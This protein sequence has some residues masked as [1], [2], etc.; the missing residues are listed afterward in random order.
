MKVIKRRVHSRS[1]NQ[2]IEI[3]RL[4]LDVTIIFLTELFEGMGRA[5]IYHCTGF[6]EVGNFKYNTNGMSVGK[7]E[8]KTLT[9]THHDLVEDFWLKMQD[10][11]RYKRTINALTESI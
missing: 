9:K 11:K 8:F 4:D 7:R 5:T 6:D 10:E 2:L 1:S 3:M